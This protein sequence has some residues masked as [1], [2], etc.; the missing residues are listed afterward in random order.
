MSA[1]G[2]DRP[3][4]ETT[5]TR[6]INQDRSR[7]V[8]LT[9]FIILNKELPSR[10]F[11]QFSTTS[12]VLAFLLNIVRLDKRSVATGLRR[13]DF[14]FVRRQYELIFCGRQTIDWLLGSVTMR[15]FLI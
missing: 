13:V 15:R 7:F 11:L 3:Q 6:P 12:F 10:T 4:S 1:P 9:E 14:Q 5:H 8:R 2:C